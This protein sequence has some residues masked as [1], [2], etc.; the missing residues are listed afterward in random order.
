MMMRPLRCAIMTGATSRQQ[1][2]GE[3]T[4]VPKNA[5]A[6]KPDVASTD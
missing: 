5:H 3:T 6:C 1:V 4:E 2:I